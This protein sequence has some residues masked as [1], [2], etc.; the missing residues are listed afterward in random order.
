MVLCSREELRMLPGREVQEVVV[1][2]GVLFR[3]RHVLEEERL[4]VRISA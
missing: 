2:G 1:P 3:L 4:A